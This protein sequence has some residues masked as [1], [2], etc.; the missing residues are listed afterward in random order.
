MLPFLI[1]VLF[2]F[3][4]Q[5]VLKFKRKLRRQRVKQDTD[6]RLKNTVSIPGSDKCI[7]FSKTRRPAE[8]DT[9][10]PIQWVSGQIP[11]GKAAG[12]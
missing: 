8:G 4:I 3:Y 12:A 1:P 9:H 11:G 5:V 6:W 10:P 7:L 2:T